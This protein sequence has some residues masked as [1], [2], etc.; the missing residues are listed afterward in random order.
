[1]EESVWCVGINSLGWRQMQHK[2]D[3]T[4]QRVKVE[5]W[6]CMGSMVW[7]VHVRYSLSYPL[8]TPSHLLPSD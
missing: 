7:H 6:S 1:M 5:S 2:L 3:V 4:T 8:P